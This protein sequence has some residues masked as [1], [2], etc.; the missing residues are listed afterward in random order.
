MW[1][2]V[3]LWLFGVVASENRD[4][5]ARMLRAHLCRGE[6]TMQGVYRGSYRV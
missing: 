2:L 3:V 1:A 5:S 4:L 6:Q